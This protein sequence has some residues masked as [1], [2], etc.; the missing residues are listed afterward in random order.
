MRGRVLT[1]LHDITDDA[2]LVKVA[3]ATLCAEW[4]FESNLDV[5]NVMSVPG[6]P[7]E[8]VAKPED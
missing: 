1:I 8:F 2:K 6:S 4:L 3:T 7:K 5:I